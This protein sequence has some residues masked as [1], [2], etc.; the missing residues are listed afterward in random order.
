MP[1][2]I[3]Y[4]MNGDTIYRSLQS[5]SSINI[6][7]DR[8]QL[9]H[10]NGTD[11]IPI[12]GLDTVCIFRDKFR[13][14]VGEMA[15]W[16][17]VLFSMEQ[18]HF[19]KD[20]RNGQ[21]SA[22]FSFY[23][24]DSIPDGYFVYTEFDEEGNPEYTNLNDSCVVIVSNV[25]GEYFD[26]VVIDRNMASFSMDSIPIPV[27]YGFREWQDLTPGQQTIVR[28]QSVMGGLSMVMGGV[29]MAAGCAMLIP[30]VNIAVGVTIALGGAATFISGALLTTRATDQMISDGTHTEGFEQWSRWIGL[31]GAVASGAQGAS[32][33]AQQLAFYAATEGGGAVADWG[34]INLETTLNAAYIRAQRI[35]HMHLSATGRAALLDLGN[36][37]VRLFGNVNGKLNPNDRF[38]IMVAR[39]PKAVTVEYCELLSTAHEIGEFYCDFSGLEPCGGYYYRSYYYA[40]ELAGYDTISPWIVSDPK[41]FKM[42]GVITLVHEQGNYSNSYWLHGKFQDVA[43]QP[44]HTVGFCYSYTNEEPTYDDEIMEQ[45]VYDNGEFTGHL[46]TN[47]SYDVCYYRAYAFINGEIAYGEVMQLGGAEEREC[48]LSIY[49]ETNGTNWTNQNNWG[50]ARP[51]SEWYG[52]V[53]DENGHVVSLSLNN[54]NLSGN[55]EVSCLPYLNHLNISNNGLSSIAI[56]NTSISNIELSNCIINHGSINIYDSISSISILNIPEMGNIYGSCDSLYVS[57]CQFGNIW[58]PFSGITCS[59]AIIDNCHMYNCYLFSSILIFRNSTTTDTWYCSTS[60]K[61]VIENSY[62]S[63]ICGSTMCGCK[64]GWWDFGCNTL[65]ILNNATLW[66]PNNN[67]NLLITITRT[68]YGSQWDSLFGD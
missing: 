48:L 11:L 19:Y 14:Y 59:K 61:L 49:Y 63:T 21:P 30:G 10:N 52:V 56:S 15:D 18:I 5:V 25:Y 35:R 54:N 8:Q 9:I 4:Q 60:Q 50:S 55:F 28:R 58:G 68:L 2:Y 66:R 6:N 13:K 47:S 51:I 40:S 46:Y 23:M 22:L 3:M 20:N 45:T 65:I 42:P 29:T 41:S 64:D 32:S 38:G 37:S 39:D 12:S 7:S 16:D 17:E 34:I 31:V 53:T 44:T 57:N 1:Y 43:N 24:N 67:E 26:A 36:S 27:I 33:L 62:C